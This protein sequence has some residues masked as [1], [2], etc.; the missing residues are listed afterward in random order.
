MTDPD[1]PAPAFTPDE[2]KHAFHAF[3][4]RYKLTKL[5]EESKLGGGRP[6]TSGKKADGIGIVPPGEFPREIWRELTRQGRL[7]DLGG[8]FYRL[9]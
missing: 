1:P 6:T 8:G 4:K 2:L 5:N 9:P 3:K 7:K